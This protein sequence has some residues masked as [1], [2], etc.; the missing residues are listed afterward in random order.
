M[1]SDVHICEQVR[2][3]RALYA[4]LERY[5]GRDQSVRDQLAAQADRLFEAWRTGAPAA[6]VQIANWLPG[7]LGPAASAAPPTMFTLEDAR[8]TL[9]REHGFRD[10]AHVEAEGAAPPHGP[11]EDAVDHA[12]AG[13]LDALEARLDAEPALVNERSA[14]AHRAGLVHYMTANGVETYRQMT[15]LN[16]DRVL[17]F[18]VERGADVNAEATMYGGA[19][20]LGL[21]LTSGH[22]HEA[23]LTEKMAAI[24]R[25]A[26]AN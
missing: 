18:L 7:H 11:F 21:L 16:A 1:R 5:A 24:L 6:R 20:P 12:L 13:D 2:E 19:R 9:A 14:Y 26:G 23:G 3:V 15:P 25:N 10:W 8:L 17:S 4:P 22:P